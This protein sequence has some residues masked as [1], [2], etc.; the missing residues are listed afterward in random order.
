MASKGKISEIID[1]EKIKEQLN[2]LNIGLSLAATNIDKIVLEAVKMNAAFKDAK[3]IKDLTDSYVKLNKTEQDGK[4]AAEKLLQATAN[5]EKAELNLANAVKK[6]TETSEK[7]LTEYQ[8]LSQEHVKLRNAA[9]ELAV[10]YGINDKRTIEAT[11]ASNL[12][13]KKLNEIDKSLGQNQ[14][15]VGSYTESIIAASKQMGLGNTVI[16]KAVDSYQSYK[17]AAVEAGAGTGVLNGAMKMLAKNPIMPIIAIAA[18]IF[19]TLKEAIGRNA[20]IVDKFTQALAPLQKIFGAVLGV[21]SDFVLVLVEG[22]SKAMTAATSLFGDAGAA[23]NEYKKSLEATEQAEKNLFN[24][25]I[26]EK[27]QQEEI[28]NLMAVANNRMVEGKVRHEAISKAIQM[29]SDLALK[30]AKESK[31]I[32]D[33]KVAELEAYYDL[34]GGLVNSNH[35]LTK[36]A[37]DKMSQEDKDAYNSKLDDY[38]SYADKESELRKESSRKRGTISK[39]IIAQEKEDRELAIALMPEGLA[40]QLALLQSNFLAKKA[41]AIVSFKEEQ[42]LADSDLKQKLQKLKDANNFTKKEQEKQN[43]FLKDFSKERQDAAY[44][45]DVIALEKKKQAFII[46][47]NAEKA[48]IIANEAAI[49]QA[50]IDAQ[51]ARIDLIRKQV[52]GEFDAKK[53]QAKEEADAT[54]D[55]SAAARD[56]AFSI[57]NKLAADK[58][59][60]QKDGYDKDLANLKLSFTEKRQA[61]QKELKDNLLLTLSEKAKLNEQLKL[62]DKLQTKAEE[63]LSLQNSI[64]ILSIEKQSIENRL[65]LVEIGSAEELKLSLESVENE[66][67]VRLLNATKSG[68]DVNQINAV[69]DKKRNDASINSTLAG[70]DKERSAILM[71]SKQAQDAEYTQLVNAYKNKLISKEEFEK[72]KLALT[73]KY[74]IENLQSNLNFAND[75]LS[76]VGEDN[77]KYLALLKARN[78]AE[79]ALNEGKNAK[80]VSDE[81]KLKE[82]KKLI[83]DKEWEAAKAGLDTYAAFKDIGFQKEL[84]DIDVRSKADEDA[85]E[86]ELKAAGNDE[87]LKTKI[88]AKYDAAEKKREIERKKIATEKAKSDKLTALFNIGL[89]T[90]KAIVEAFP[91][92]ILMAA[93]AVLGGLQAAV[94]LATPIP[95][96]K[97]GR[98]GGNAE[99]AFVGDAG[100]EGI[101]LETGEKFLTPNRETLVHLPSGASVI[102]NYELYKNTAFEGVPTFENSYNIEMQLMVNELAAVKSG[103]YFVAETVKN[104]R[105]LHLNITKSGFETL[106]KD[107]NSWTKFVNNRYRN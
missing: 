91:N 8:K 72:R 7:Q 24:L 83:H 89:S 105:E 47:L 14:R 36:E 80:I 73:N 32:L 39:A 19:M 27:T 35:Q 2:V 53:L 50:K 4:I 21:V 86:R 13:D 77:F 54:R 38:I 52:L 95:K 22:F 96:Y 104:K 61:I 17:V 9:K 46:S 69:F 106:A 5:R 1:T 82:I 66:R 23:A 30:E 40:K 84:A 6:T 51:A 20:E 103:I 12:Y 10:Q 81:E 33:G 55:A 49:K 45:S 101:E 44:A 48:A 92:P 68:E 59:A 107:G 97:H 60:L 41:T 62:Q 29:Q 67:Q 100:T 90:A 70:M 63:E 43:K 16:G 75:E 94:V 87:A 85:R 93:A 64:K 25:K 98:R 42:S 15:K 37:N 74:S 71:S 11:A 102:P 34:S 65:T 26:Q 18:I 99:L 78:D 28:N 3:G 58:I 31:T 57:E 88:N 79:I 56:L 76:K